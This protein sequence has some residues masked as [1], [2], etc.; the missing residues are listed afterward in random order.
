[1]TKRP[2]KKKVAFKEPVLDPIEIQEPAIEPEIPPDVREEPEKVPENEKE[3]E[4]PYRDVPALNRVSTPKFLK[5]KE[6]IPVTSKE[7]AYRIKAPIDNMGEEETLLETVLRTQVTLPLGQLVK[8]SPQLA[9]DMRKMLTKVRSPLK[10]KPIN[11][12]LQESEYPY[13]EDDISCQLDYDAIHIEDLPKVDS[14][15]ISTEEDTALDPRVKAGYMVVPDPYLQYLASL[16]DD[17]SPRQV[18][19]ANDSASLRVIFP[20]VD[21]KH[22][23][24]AVI[25][26]G[27]QIVSMALSEAERLNITWDPDIQIY[28][29]SANG[30]LK[31]SA[32]LARNVPFVVGEIAAYLQVHIIDQP[33]YKI[34]L[35][36]PFDILTES[37]VNNSANGG[38]VITLKDPNTGR[39][40][41]VPTHPRGTYSAATRPE[42][43]PQNFKAPTHPG[44]T[45]QAEFKSRR[46]T[47]EKVKD[48]S[49]ESDSDESSDSEDDEPGFQRSSRN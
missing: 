21:G 17:E 4:L 41:T 1:M 3:P 33:A 40:C 43:L 7:R 37:Q 27:S 11:A 5:A 38:Q 26:S 47:V 24:E 28:M 36:R 6:N 13:M 16:K 14:L 23:I 15:Y 42:P 12:L 39:R 20:L 18:F 25:D 30:Q 22:R 49:E 10:F 29:Q 35:G 8:A 46:A 34:L 32:G 48:E 9:L 31:K 44:P 2:E 45:T 19:V